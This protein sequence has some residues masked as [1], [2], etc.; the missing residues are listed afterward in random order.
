M[1]SAQVIATLWRLR[2]NTIERGIKANVNSLGRLAV[3][4]S[5]KNM[6]RLIYAFPVPIRANGKPAYKRTFRLRANERFQ[7]DPDGL[8]GALLNIMPYAEVRHEAN[9]PGRRF[10]RHTAHWREETVNELRDIVSRT[11]HDTIVA[12]FTTFRGDEFFGR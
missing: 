9:K 8:G 10:M 1:P 12:A 7:V 11:H 4:I 5:V 2:A 3:K 6:N